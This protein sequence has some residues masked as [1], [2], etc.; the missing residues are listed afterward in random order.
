MNDGSNEQKKKEMHAFL[1]LTVVLAP[2]LAVAIVG[3]YG[4]MVWLYQ[5][6]AGPPVG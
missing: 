3:S 6:I 2:L 5:L 1:F 4:L